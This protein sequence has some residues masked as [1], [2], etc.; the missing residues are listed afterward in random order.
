MVR[1]GQDLLR[2]DNHLG[3]QWSS[4]KG[5]PRPLERENK[6]T[7][8]A[9]KLLFPFQLQDAEPLPPPRGGFQGNLSSGRMSSCQDFHQKKE[10]CC[11]LWTAWSGGWW[12]CTQ[13][14][15]ETRWSLWS[16]SFQAILW[17]CDPS[18]ATHMKL[19]F[20]EGSVW[21]SVCRYNAAPLL[22]SCS[23]VPMKVHCCYV[24]PLLWWDLWKFRYPD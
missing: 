7:G 24:N 3:N 23:T 12:P 2:T 20:S 9:T 19:P 11:I 1:S 6:W 10:F 5:F 22:D 16:F 13:Q 15:V 21:L 18:A 8:V 17:F 14:G 4:W